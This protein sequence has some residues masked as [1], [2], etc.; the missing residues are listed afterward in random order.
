MNLSL[1]KRIASSFGLAN[2][3]VFII[4]FTVF[5]YLDSLNSQIEAI[6]TNTNKVNLLTDEI[7]ISAVSI[8][9]MQK[10]ILTNKAK[11]ED[12]NKLNFLC[13][14]FHEQLEKLNSY[15]TEVQ[16]K[17]IISKMIGY[18]DSLQTLLSKISVR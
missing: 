18:V 11:E 10:K 9:K 14:D 1:K 15:Y 8:L 17:T 4:G 5:Y 3:M 7:R 12:L 13:D 16:I 2:V 6:T